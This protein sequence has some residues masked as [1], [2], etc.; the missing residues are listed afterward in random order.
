LAFPAG[1][2]RYRQGARLFHVDTAA[3]RRSMA[4]AMLNRPMIRAGVRTTLI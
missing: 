4:R 2:E 3:R 1:F